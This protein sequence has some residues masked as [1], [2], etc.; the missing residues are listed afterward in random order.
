MGEITSAG[1]SSRLNKCVAPAIGEPSHPD[2]ATIQ[3]S[4]R[5]ECPNCR[6][7]QPRFDICE[8]CGIV[9][10]KYIR[11]RELQHSQLRAEQIKLKA[12]ELRVDSWYDDLFNQRL[13]GV[14][15]ISVLAIVLLTLPLMCTVKNIPSN[16][17]L[18][19]QQI[20]QQQGEIKRHE[21]AYKVGPQFLEVVALLND[22][23]ELCVIQC[24]NYQDTWYQKGEVATPI[25]LKFELTQNMRDNLNRIDANNSRFHSTYPGYA[26]S[27]YANSKNECSR[28]INDL[29]KLHDEM[30]VKA[31][32]YHTMYNDLDSLLADVLSKKS[33]LNSQ[34][35]KCR[36]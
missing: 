24:R 25:N 2:I 9:I 26:Y 27:S 33:E 21:D 7:N 19:G 20:V 32:S 16:T 14:L 18:S 35:S 30:Y 29:V 5:M 6:A 13:R 22:N 31:T 11:A 34:I 10:E 15:Y 4:G 8:S 36:P 3:Q 17:K 28:A 12:D 23:I 1:N